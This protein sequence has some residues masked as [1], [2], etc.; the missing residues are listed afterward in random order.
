MTRLVDADAL[1]KRFEEECAGECPICI[2]SHE[3]CPCGLIKTAPTVEITEEQAIDKLHETGWMQ[4]HDKE[5]TKR[6]T[7][8]CGKCEYYRNNYGYGQCFAQ[9]NAPRV[10]YN[11]SCENFKYKE[12]EGQWVTLRCTNCHDRTKLHISSRIGIY[13]LAEFKKQRLVCLKCGADMKVVRQR[14][15]NRGNE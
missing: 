12:W 4:R 15:E 9:K 5:M 8:K 13:S 14:K 1:E 7:G 2:Y 11:H 6:P 3:G 10:D